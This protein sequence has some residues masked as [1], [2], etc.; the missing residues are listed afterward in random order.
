MNFS[1]AKTEVDAFFQAYG[2]N[3]KAQLLSR[4]KGKVY[5]LYCLA[6]TIEILKS[7]AAVSVLFVGNTVDLKSSPGRVDRTKAYFVI[8]RNGLDLELHTDVE[9]RTLSSTYAAGVVGPSSYHEIDLVLLEYAQDRQRPAHDQ[10]V[11]GVECKSH[12]NFK[13]EIVRQVLGVRREL[14][15]LRPAPSKLQAFLFGWY[16][17]IRATPASEYWLAFTDPKGIRYGVGPAVFD[18]EFKHWCPR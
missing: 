8:S 6:K 18:I 4:E 13:K 11:L 7:Y 5:E 14:S 12:A 3:A 15:L 2:A 17:E 10:I 1:A 16:H 9:V